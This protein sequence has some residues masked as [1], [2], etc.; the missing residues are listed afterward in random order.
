MPLRAMF[1]DF[2]GLIIDTETPEVE[3]WQEI[4]VEHGLVFPDEVWIHSI[5]R[6]ADEILEQP[7]DVLL[8]MSSD[9]IDVAQVQDDYRQRV[10]F[11]ILE[12]PV[13]P[14]V[15]RLAT[16]ARAAGLPVCVVSSSRHAWVDTHLPRL[17]IAGLFDRTV[18]RDDAA[19]A[20][21]HPDLYELACSLCGVLPSEASTFEDSPNGV[22]AAN[23]AGVFSIA[24]PNGLTGRL[25]LS[26]ARRR[27]AS[28]DEVSLA[29]IERWIDG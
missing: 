6:G 5:G 29:Q 7:I 20:K 3:I 13:R 16:E 18:C 17:G 2:D 11:R 12:K 28:I 25:D 9:S 19:R 1:F 14:G 4:F 8:R 21:P 27:L 10:T 15:V 23:A 22:T 24:V 26:H